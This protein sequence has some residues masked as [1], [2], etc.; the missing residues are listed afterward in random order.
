MSKIAKK[1][2]LVAYPQ[3]YDNLL[4]TNV[5]RRIG[6]RQGYDKA[7]QDFL[8]KACDYLQKNLWRVIIE[9]GEFRQRFVTDFKKYM[10]NESEN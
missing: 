4:D 5:H 2:A 10:Q 9:D 8:E 7:T 6:Y 1:K 3:K